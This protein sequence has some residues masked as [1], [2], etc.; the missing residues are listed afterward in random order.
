ME[1]FGGLAWTSEEDGFAVVGVITSTTRATSS[2][3]REWRKVLSYRLAGARDQCKSWFVKRPSQRCSPEPEDAEPLGT[4]S[5]TLCWRPTVYQISGA[6]CGVRCS[7]IARGCGMVVSVHVVH[8]LARCCRVMT[9]LFLVLPG[10]T[11]R[12]VNSIF[13]DGRSRVLCHRL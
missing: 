3:P 9:K 12:L 2:N 11:S 7:G 5:D 13:V 10:F 8:W 4:P 1:L 6:N